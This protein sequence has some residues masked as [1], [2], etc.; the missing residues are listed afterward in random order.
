A[1][2]HLPVD[3]PHGAPPSI[4]A[5]VRGKRERERGADSNIARDA[6][7]AAVCL[8][9]RAADGEPET[10]TGS[11]GVGL[12]PERD[13][14]A[15][16]IVRRYTGTR[17]AYDEFHTPVGRPRRDVDLSS[18]GRELDRVAAEVGEHLQQTLAVRRQ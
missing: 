7:R 16:Q 10:D 11:M 18:L 14:D 5:S 17:V 9:D 2:V 15:R 13:E 4:V 6:Y 3:S 12:L 8:H 1:R